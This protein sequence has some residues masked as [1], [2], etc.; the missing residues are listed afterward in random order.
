MYK[1]IISLG[2][3]CEAALQIQRYFGTVESSLFTW[4]YVEDN[5]LLV[6]CIKNLDK[7]IKDDLHLTGWNMYQNKDFKVSFHGEHILHLMY[8]SETRKPEDITKEEIEEDIKKIKSKLVYLI[9]KFK[10][11]LNSG[12]KILF[13]YKPRPY[14]TKD[15]YLEFICGLNNAIKSI[16]DKS[17]FRI[18]FIKNKNDKNFPV[19]IYS[20]SLQFFPEDGNVQ[21]CDIA[22]WQGILNSINGVK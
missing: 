1:H 2:Y 14:E 9:K 21:N 7:L 15:D 16:S 20:K 17:N 18:L 12:E 8:H 22:S 19:N 4:A 6:D 13:I 3:N 11:V 10:T 5:N